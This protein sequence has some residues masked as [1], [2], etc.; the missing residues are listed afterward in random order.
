MACEF[1]IKSEVDVVS[2]SEMAFLGR[3]NGHM[4]IL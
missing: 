4:S 1:L 3:E 2:V